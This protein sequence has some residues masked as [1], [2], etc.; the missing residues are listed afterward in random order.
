LVGRDFTLP[1]DSGE[2]LVLV[3]GGIGITPFVGQLAQRVRRD[4]V[5]V[6]APGSEL[7]YPEE[8]A[9][10]G[11]PVVLVSHQRPRVLPGHWTFVDGTRV[12]EQIL[13]GAVPDLDR[14][15]GFVSGPPEMVRDVARILRSIGARSVRTDAFS[16]Y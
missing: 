13:R 2:P 16:G 7:A 5:L 3:A 14:R 15:A 1:A 12:T 8:L 6:Y 10:T 4:A 9:A 11:V